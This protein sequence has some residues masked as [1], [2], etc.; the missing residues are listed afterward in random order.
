[1]IIF[2]IAEEEQFTK[3]R[4]HTVLADVAFLLTTKVDIKL[5]KRNRCSTRL[6]KHPFTT[7]AVRKKQL[8]SKTVRYAT[9]EQA[10]KSILLQKE[11][12]SCQH[13]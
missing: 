3:I 8:I 2:I 10:K 5:R 12:D 13:L 7:F 1:M 6:I 4:G 11:I 9:N